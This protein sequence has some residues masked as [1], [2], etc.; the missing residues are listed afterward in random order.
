MILQ[1]NLN[2]SMFV[3]WEM[4]RHHNM[5]WK[6][7]SFASR[8]DWTQRAIFW[9]VLAG[10]FA[11][12]KH[13]LLQSI[14]IHFPTI[15]CELTIYTNTHEQQPYCVGTLSEMTERS[16]ERRVRQETGWLA[17][18]QLLRVP[19]VR[20]TTDTFLFISH[21]TNVLL[22]KSHCNIVIG[23]RIIKELPGLVGSRTPCISVIQ[24][25]Y[26]YIVLRSYSPRFTMVGSCTASLMHL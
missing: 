24:K 2:R 12:N 19:T 5:H 16:A 17:G 26:F 18:E 6:W 9:K 14:P 13:S 15:L 4:W 3:V 23:V 25:L 1:R 21:T 11:N 10:M 7:P 8:Q 20:R 22:F